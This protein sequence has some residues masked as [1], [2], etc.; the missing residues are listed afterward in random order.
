MRRRI[1]WASVGIAV[2]AVLSLLTQRKPCQRMMRMYPPFLPSTGY[3]KPLST[4]RKESAPRPPVS[5]PPT[6][7][8]LS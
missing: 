7:R 1:V 8:E 6:H 5:P 2:F 4:G 3:G